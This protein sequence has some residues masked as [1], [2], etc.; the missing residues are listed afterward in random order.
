MRTV[1]LLAVAAIFAAAAP[2]FGQPSEI[3]PFIGFQSGGSLA[4]NDLN[5]P[6]DVTPVYGV[7]LTWDWAPHSKLDVLLS[8]QQTS[9]TR[10]DPFEPSVTA[11]ATIDY[12]DLGGRYVFDPVSHATG[13]IA[14]TTGLTHVAV[15]GG[16]GIAFNFAAGGGLDLRLSQR[17]ALRFDGRWHVTFGGSGSIGCSSIGGVGTC[18]GFISGGGLGQF[19]GSAGFVYHF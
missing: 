15:E 3:T 14:F 6:L 1:R 7:T 18:V 4:V 16:Q 17:T 13:Y 8:H 12:F 10:N 9:A 2:L 11:D 19:T 5:T